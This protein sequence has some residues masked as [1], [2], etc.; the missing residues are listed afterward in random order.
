MARFLV[1][2]T[3]ES[4]LERRWSSR[5][6]ICFSTISY[7]SNFN[8]T[9]LTKE[10]FHRPHAS[11][12]A[13]SSIDT[14]DAPNSVTAV[15]PPDLNRALYLIPDATYESNYSKQSAIPASHLA[16]PYIQEYATHAE[17]WHKQLDRSAHPQWIPIDKL[18]D[19]HWNRVQSPLMG[20]ADI[21]ANTIISTDDMPLVEHLWREEVVTQRHPDLPQLEA[22]L[23]TF[24]EVHMDN[25]HLHHLYLEFTGED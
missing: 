1:L 15:H 8:H 5:L 2:V 20:P 18:S 4:K 7:S 9:Q 25:S 24:D 22:T 10:R 11:P 12:A 19:N 13:S 21:D 23:A 17:L 6:E 16:H 3:P 14:R